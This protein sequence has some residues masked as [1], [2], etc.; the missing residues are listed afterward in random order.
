MFSEALP[1]ALALIGIVIL[2][3]SLLSGVIERT[4]IPQVAIFL[5]LGTVLGPA[6]LHLV[7]L[8][9]ESPTLQW[10]ATLGLV[11]VLFTDAIAMDFGEIRHPRRLLFTI[12]GPATLIPAVIIAFAAWRLLGLGPLPAFI[13]GAALASTDPV[14]LRGLIRRSS[15]PAPVREA[16]RLEGGINDVVLLPVIVLSILA[17]GQSADLGS[18]LARH[19]VGLFLLG[20]GLGA[21]VGYIAITLLEQVRKRV[22]VRRDYE[23]LY[24]LGVAFTA[25]AVAEA[26]GGSGFLAAFAAGVVIALLDVEL[27][28]CFLDYGQATAEMFLLFTFVAFGAAL[29][30]SGLSVVDGP[31]LVFAA[32]ALLAR[33]AVL[34][35]T[36]RWIG[37]ERRTRRIIAWSGPRGLSSLLLVLLPVFAGVPQG[38]RL[39]AITSLVVLLSVA[40][41]GTGIAVF[42]RMTE[43]PPPKPAEVISAPVTTQPDPDRGVPERITIDE[44]RHLWAAGVPVVLADVRTERSYRADNLKAV[45]AV[46]LS[47]D[48]AVRQARELGL[49]HHGTLVL[50][51][52]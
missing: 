47:P 28:D 17:L 7:E 3:S 48:D 36:L 40:I 46:R 18:Q 26:V 24:A 27:C 30:W 14:M 9:L 10:I 2:V 13:V 45:G 34:L 35:P 21:V 1:A 15:L 52:A 20:P 19:A 8:T 33:T 50:Y 32:V 39:F 43:G 41:H 51:C 38:E 16:L 37:V 49:D 31:T 44:L 25:F 11:L 42:I 22:G 6:G 4:G 23:S 29:I 12:L 5:L